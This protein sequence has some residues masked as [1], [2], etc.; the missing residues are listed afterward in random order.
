VIVT[1]LDHRQVPNFES[2]LYV[3]L[4]RARDRLVALIEAGTLQMALG[5]SR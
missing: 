5:G 2:L 4:T 1:D 3:G